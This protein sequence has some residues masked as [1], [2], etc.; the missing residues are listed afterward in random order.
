MMIYT[1]GRVGAV[2]KMKI[3]DY[4]TQGRRG[5]VR[6]AAVRSGHYVGIRECCA[7]VDKTQRHALQ[8]PTDVTLL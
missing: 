7:A 8:R 4:Y 2:I 1:F 6:H 5:W 3:E